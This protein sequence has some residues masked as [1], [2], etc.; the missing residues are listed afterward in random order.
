MIVTERFTLNPLTKRSLRQRKEKFGYGLLGL[1]TY[2]RCVAVGTKVLT[3]DLRW[4]P[5]ETLKEGDML[6]G[7]D[8]YPLDY[9]RKFKRSAVEDVGI[10][11]D[12]CF[13]VVTDRGTITV[14]TEHPFLARS[15][16]KEKWV[17]KKVEQLRE[18]DSI[19]FVSEPW[20]SEDGDSWLAG[21]AD[22]E[23]SVSGSRLSITQLT[24][25]SITERMIEEIDSRGFSFMFYQE[26]LQH[27]KPITVASSQ[28]IT[29]TMQFLGTVRPQ[30]LLETWS[31]KIDELKVGLP[32][33]GRAIVQTVIPVG[34]QDIVHLQTSTRTFIAD[35]FVCHNTYSRMKA[36]GSQERW[37]D[38]VI[39]CVEG[40]LSI[41]KTHY[42][43]NGL[44]WDEDTWQSI[45][46]RMANA[47][48]DI[49]MLPPGRGLIYSPV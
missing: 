25:R 19:R 1:A 5:A 34:E 30:R 28:N 35:G 18:G 37:S 12:S 49:R 20:E 43:M 13:D 10:R 32:R 9:T 21:F 23:G 3:D 16:E 39:R 45:A 22:A 48:F 42:L 7:V 14:S 26:G 33:D 36:D 44:Y 40:A 41:R 31:N 27:R 29:S 8:E 38:T 2:Y 24:G 47:I 15:S 46:I 4:V 11:K 17:W 6:L